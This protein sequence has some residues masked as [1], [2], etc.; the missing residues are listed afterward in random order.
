LIAGDITPSQLAAHLNFKCSRKNIPY[1]YVSDLRQNIQ[2]ALGFPCIALGFKKGSDSFL[3][4]IKKISELYKELKQSET[5]LV[6]E[7]KQESESEEEVPAVVQRMLEV[8]KETKSPFSYLYRSSCKERVFI[9][10]EVDQ[11][12]PEDGFIALNTN[13]EEVKAMSKERRNALPGISHNIIEN[14]KKKKYFN[15]KSLEEEGI[16]MD[17]TEEVPKKKIK[18]DWVIDKKKSK[19]NFNYAPANVIKYHS[20][21]DRKEKSQK[22]KKEKFST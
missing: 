10:E 18:K 13:D 20:N 14:F 5:E 15:F 6:E 4:I 17:E 16:G 7:V 22:E 9:P 1:I 2:D 21:I 11:E 8:K 12:K 19:G 3:K